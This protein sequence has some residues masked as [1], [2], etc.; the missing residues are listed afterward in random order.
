MNNSIKNI[1]E[2][3]YHI[4][5]NYRPQE[6]L[7]ACTVCC[8]SKTD[9]AALKSIAIR[10]V[11]RDLILEYQ[12]AAKPETLN[13]DELKYFT[14]KFLELVAKNQFPSYEPILSFTRFGMLKLEDWNEE[15]RALLDEFSELYFKEQLSYKNE[16]FPILDVLLMFYKGGFKIPNILGVWEKESSI[17]STLLFADLLDIIHFSK[18]GIP[19]VEDA[20]SDEKFSAIVCNWIFSEPVKKKFRQDFENI[21]MSNPTELDDK[22]LQSLSWKYELLK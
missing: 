18:K 11:S 17:M 4:F 20:F 21:I 14:P 19:R 2:K 8:M 7:D 16:D 13:P 12:D 15:E 1:V 9:E 5:S 10:Q 3:A 22:V 6:Y